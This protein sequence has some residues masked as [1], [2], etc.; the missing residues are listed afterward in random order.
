M[1]ATL[2]RLHS[3]SSNKFNTTLST[4]LWK[5]W[6]RRFCYYCISHDPRSYFCWVQHEYRS[7]I[8]PLWSMGPVLSPNAI[9]S[10]IRPMFY[11]HHTAIERWKHGMCVRGLVF[12]VPS[13]ALCDRWNFYFLL[14]VLCRA[15]WT[16]FAALGR[17]EAN[18]ETSNRI[19]KQ[20]KN[21]SCQGTVA[22]AVLL[23][24]GCV[25]MRDRYY[26]YFKKL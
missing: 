26:R 10:I 25:T 21:L 15:R 11:M 17:T 18:K 24:T 13:S 14:D 23:N 5:M 22:V 9:N 4:I 1:T 2:K 6:C 7:P 16:H 8:K 3:A 20:M 19:Q 12:N